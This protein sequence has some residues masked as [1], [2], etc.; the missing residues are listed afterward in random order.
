MKKIRKIVALALAMVMMM[1]M[2][3]TAFAAETSKTV[4]ISNLAA[5]EGTV[6]YAQVIKE[7]R[8][9]SS[10]WAFV[11]TA[12]EKKFLETVEADDAQ[13]AL[14]DFADGKYKEST[15][16]EALKAMKEANLLTWTKS[17]SDTSFTVSAPGYYAVN[18]EGKT[19]AEGQQK[20][21]YN[22]AAIGVLPS[23]FDSADVLKL[24]AKKAPEKLVK[25]V[26]DTTYV[27]TAQILTYTI[28]ADVPF[29]Y[30]G[31]ENVTFKVYDKLIGAEMLNVSDDKTTVTVKVDGVDKVAKYSE[32]VKDGKAR[33]CFELDL[34]EMVVPAGQNFQP[35][36]V[37]ITYQA[38]VTDV[39]VDNI[40]YPGYGEN[41]PEDDSDYDHVINYSGKV[42]LIKKDENDTTKTL[43]GA[44]FV[45]LNGDQT[46][47]AEVVDGKIAAW[48]D[49]DKDADT[50]AYYLTT[51][52]NGQI[53]VK[54]LD[55]DL[56]YFFV[57]KKAPTGYTVDSTPHE[58]T[59]WKT[60]IAANDVQ[61]ATLEVLDSNLIRLPFTGGMGTTIFTVL[62]VAIMAIAA[63]LFFASKRK[64]SK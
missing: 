29:A 55:K 24:V 40:S 38:K 4:Q 36:T 9:T 44:S 64:A 15:V 1:A 61:E 41:D 33:Q 50:S 47:V 3:I 5:G 39:I 43:P 23:D 16:A 59:N 22:M 42:T 18:I 14:K 19:P 53:E 57:E 20:Y 25:T 7:D 8:T 30:E 51:D 27:E 58:V 32:D 54:G 49:Y 31:Q 56:K 11:S 48:K 26:D 34:T 21:S 60:S 37:V 13:T 52:E 6:F 17:S 12:V 10:G 46:K 45:L 63:A 2:S 28:K 35:H 62:G